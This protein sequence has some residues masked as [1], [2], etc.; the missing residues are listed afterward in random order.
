[1]TYIAVLHFPRSIPCNAHTHVSEGTEDHRSIRST[2]S[3]IIMLVAIF[4]DVLF[5]GLGYGKLQPHCA[6]M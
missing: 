3:N 6:R 1:M 5:G 2:A 4:T